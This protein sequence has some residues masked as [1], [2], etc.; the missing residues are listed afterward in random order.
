[1]ITS[2]EAIR[3]AQQH[4]Y[5]AGAIETPLIR[6]YSDATDDEIWLKCENLQP[7]GSFKVRGAANALAHATA[8]QLTA[9][10]YTASAGNMAQAVAYVA[11][12][13]R[14]G[15]VV[16]V[17]PTH[18]P[19]AKR[20]A[21]VRLGASVCD[22]PFDQWWQVLQTRRF[23][24]LATRFFVHPV[25]D[26]LVVAGNGTVG[27]EIITQLSDVD[28]IIVPYGGGGLSCG[29]AVAA[30]A[31]RPGVRVWAAEVDTSAAFAAALANGEPTTIEYKPS[32]VDGIG[33]SSVLPDMWPHARDLLAG[34][35][36]VSV[37]QAA[38]ALR[39][40]L[41]RNRLVVEGA[42]AAAVAAA[43]VHRAKLGRKVVVVLSGGCIDSHKLAAILERPPV[44]AAQ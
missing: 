21:I 36:V 2:I 5:D 27:V 8:S 24:P 15:D 4:V 12:E 30:R 41:E 20:D 34:S 28:D 17:V 26:P 42:A 6:L 22:I 37:D 16:C 19:Q 32:F 39:L 13:R 7:I 23:E 33:S 14:L 38:D 31:L 43:R 40:L 44:A 10:I 25:A 1:M 35:L 9:G 29:I 3:E 11:R 18:A